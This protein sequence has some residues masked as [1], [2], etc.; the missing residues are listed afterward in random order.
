MVFIHERPGGPATKAT[1]RGRRNYPPNGRNPDTG[2][3]C[4]CLES[5]PTPCPGETACAGRCEPCHYER[6]RAEEGA[7]IEGAGKARH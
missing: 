7:A 5:C 4:T 3:F 2:L 1:S 6:L